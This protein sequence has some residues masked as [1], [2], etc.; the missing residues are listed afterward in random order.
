MLT[1]IINVND[2]APAKVRYKDMCTTAITRNDEALKFVPD[3][4]LDYK[5][6]LMVIK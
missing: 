1:E 2:R 4:F 6:Y 5:I 3:K